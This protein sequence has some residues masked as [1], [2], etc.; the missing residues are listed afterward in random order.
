MW[1]WPSHQF[2]ESIDN[3]GFTCECIRCQR[4]CVRV[5]KMVPNETCS[6]TKFAWET[7]EA[8]PF[9]LCTKAYKVCFI[10]I[11]LYTTCVTNSCS[12]PHFFFFFFFFSLRVNSPRKYIIS[13]NFFFL[14]RTSIEIYFNLKAYKRFIT[15][16][17]T[18]TRIKLMNKQIFNQFWWQI[19]KSSFT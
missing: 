15:F 18:A 11:Y 10:R 19:P 14:R 2:Y 13:R 17:L 6:N 12:C 4:A 9:W 3:V 8:R 16:L 1:I 7:R 5:G